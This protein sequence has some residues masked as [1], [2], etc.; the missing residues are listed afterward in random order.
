MRASSRL[1]CQTAK[2][3]FLCR[4]SG[5]R[6]GFHF[7][8]TCSRRS[9]G[10]VS[11]RSFPVVSLD[12]SLQNE[13]AERR[14]APMSS[15]RAHTQS[16]HAGASHR[17]AF[18]RSTAAFSILGTPLPFRPWPVVS[19][20]ASGRCTG[21]TTRACLVRREAIVQGLPGPRLLNRGRRRHSPFTSSTPAGRPS[22]EGGW[23]EI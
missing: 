20:P 4:M 19:P 21:L 8:W 16:A 6:N 13:G 5:R 9:R 17:L 22:C 7:A 1:N 18:R 11:R 23:F 10:A 15:S 2:P 3:R 14:S 12:G